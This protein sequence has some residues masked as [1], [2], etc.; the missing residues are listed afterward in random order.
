MSDFCYISNI[1]QQ[2]AKKVTVEMINCNDSGTGID[3]K[4]DLLRWE[5]TEGCNHHMG[6]I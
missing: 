6:K 4:A 1:H 5:H 3:D 2:M